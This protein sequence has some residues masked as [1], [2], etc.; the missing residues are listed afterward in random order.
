MQA[1]NEQQTK[2]LVA[3]GLLALTLTVSLV[4]GSAAEPEPYFPD[5]VQI[6]FPDVEPDDV[7]IFR[8]SRD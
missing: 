7:L 2:W 3:V 6:V 4:G 1:E 5:P 8:S